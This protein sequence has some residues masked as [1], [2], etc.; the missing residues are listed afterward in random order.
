MTAILA[1]ATTGKEL[2]VMDALTDAC[3]PHWRGIRID[4]ERRGKSRIAQPY[5]YPVLPNYI[6]ITTDDLYPLSKIKH[7]SRTVQFLTRGGVASFQAFTA[8]AD[9]AAT[10]AL[11]IVG[12]RQAIAQFKANEEIKIIA[13]AFAGQFASFKAIINPSHMHHPLISA[14]IQIFG[15][16][17][18]V[19]LDPLNTAKE[20]RR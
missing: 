11:R 17:T 5:T 7:L 9:A 10:E 13:G 2:H 6:H 16:A 18:N 20:V 8:K 15:R 1:Y 19:T 12:N 4:F 3:I 14:E